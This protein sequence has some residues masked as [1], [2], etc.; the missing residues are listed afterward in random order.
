[1]L[2]HAGRDQRQHSWQEPA[3]RQD[4]RAI[5]PALDGN[6]RLGPIKRTHGRHRAHPFH[7]SR[8]R[9]LPPAFCRHSYWRQAAGIAGARQSAC[10][11]SAACLP[12]PFGTCAAAALTRGLLVTLSASAASLFSMILA[13]MA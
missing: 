5:G 9:F 13:M 7:P 10:D 3:S 4:K 8:K 12:S 2:Q 11:Y 6:R 1:M